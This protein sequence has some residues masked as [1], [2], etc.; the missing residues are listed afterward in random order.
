MK[1]THTIKIVFL[2][3]TATLAIA[4]LHA[5]PMGTAFTYQGRLVS[6]GSAATGL[7]DFDFA[8][9][10]AA[11]NGTQQGST[12]TTNAVPVTNGYFIVVL[13]FGSAFDGNARWLDISV[14]TNGAGSYNPLTPRQPLTPTPYAV[15]ANSASN[16]LGALPA[17]Q[18]TGTFP[19][20]QL[21]GAVGNGQLAN[22]SITV[23]A[24]TGL[25]GGGVVPLGGTTTLNNGGVLSVTGNA[26][27]T[28]SMVNG[29][30]TLGDTATNANTA[31][32]I[33]KRDGSGSF[34]AGSATLSGNLNL[35]ATTAS[36][37]LITS[38]YATLVH[39]YGYKN[40]FAGYSAGNL[41]TTGPGYNTGVGFMALRS[42]TGGS[43]NT[44]YGG[45]ALYYDTEGNGNT[46]YGYMALYSN[47]NGS[48]NT[49]NG[50]RALL[51]NRSGSGN[52]ALGSE[53]GYNIT[54]GDDNI[55]IGN[56]GLATDTNII[57]IGSGQTSAFIAGVINGNGGGLTNLNATQLTSGTV[58]DS[59]L[60][61][62]V[63]LLNNSQTV[64]G[65][66]IFNNAANS[67]TGV[68]SGLTSLNASQLSS[69]TVADSRLSAN[70][71]LLNNSQTF[72]GA[73]DFHGTVTLGSTLRLIDKAHLLPRQDTDPA[74]GLSWFSTGSFAG[75]NPDGPVLWGNGGG[76]LGTVNASTNLALIWNSAGNVGI[77]A[78][79][80]EPETLCGGQ[81]STPPAPSRPTP[82]AT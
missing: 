43:D 7:Y 42:L 63:A 64:T 77:G 66:K 68:G 80:P 81:H 48:G 54:T 33:V 71:A 52:I 49:A 20:S 39:A 5:A 55:D 74:H 4:N 50:H 67:F 3:A 65:A 58:A 19:A 72:T 57:R 11:S 21:S 34:S 31:S 79:S 17:A 18:L 8:L 53:A 82:T 73:E 41:T 46:A 23:N 9:Y 61:A 37:G 32:T 30:V 27:I 75:S 59:R 24:G 12:L 26:D 76:G 47:T 56:V 35:P 25:S 62:N 2:L 45:E 6:G 1:L 15:M 40:F 69:G 51:N 28:T 44:A 10:D 60:T 29:A 16:L 78:A 14:K 38:G 13:D 36:A 22:S 70:V